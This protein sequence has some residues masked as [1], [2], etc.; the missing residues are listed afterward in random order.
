MIDL[1]SHILPAVD[2]GARNLDDALQLLR[3]A[4]AD[5]VTTQVLTPHI[6]FGVYDN[7]PASLIKAFTVF[8]KQ[9]IA[10]NIKVNLRLA[11]EVRM[12]PELIDWVESKRMLWLG[13]WQSN[14]VFLLEFPHSNIPVGSLNVVRRLR[15]QAITP[16]IVH[17]ERNREFI[18]CPEKIQPYIAAGCLL[19]I[20]AASLVGQFGRPSYRMAKMLL[21]R[22]W[23]TVIAT[24]CHN[25]N[26][27][28]PILKEGMQ[29]AAEII[30]QTAAM[31]MVTSAPAKILGIDH[32]IDPAID[33]ATDQVIGRT[34]NRAPMLAHLRV[35][36]DV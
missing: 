21:E 26:Y 23:V 29:A 13:R 8:Y 28:P 33:R 9:V 15:E 17:P 6:H 12:T 25:K 2:D 18:D 34:I 14:K 11:A 10:A 32:T 31:D 7:T 19:Q 16:M 5:G 4:V 1:H 24:D 20:T 27:R 30:G 3:L 35:T 36:V 22:N